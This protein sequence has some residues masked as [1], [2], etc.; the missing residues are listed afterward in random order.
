MKKN[1]HSTVKFAKL[2][3]NNYY[4]RQPW[5]VNERY[6]KQIQIVA[7]SE[8]ASANICLNNTFK[9]VPVSIVIIT[10]NEA[11]IIPRC[12]EMARRITDDIVIIDNGSTDETLKIAINYGCRVYKTAWDGYGAN[13]NKGINVA[14]YNWI[15]RIEAN[16]IP[17]DETISSL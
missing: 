4:L 12:I 2:L 9:M 3:Y 13:K 5:L 7:K 15:L 8:K 16:D 11:D 10:K 6:Y 17:D 14:K 1:I